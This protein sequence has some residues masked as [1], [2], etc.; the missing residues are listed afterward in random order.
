MGCHSD[1]GNRV[2]QERMTYLVEVFRTAHKGWDIRVSGRI[3]RGAFEF[4]MTG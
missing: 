2:V 1:C 3:R 4:E